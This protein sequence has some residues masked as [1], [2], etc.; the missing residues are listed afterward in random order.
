M[1]IGNGDL[2]SRKTKGRSNPRN[3]IF[4][5]QLFFINM[6]KTLRVGRGCR[7]RGTFPKRAA[8]IEYPKTRLMGD[9]TPAHQRSLSL[10]PSL[11]L[12]LTSM[13]SR[14][15]RAPSGPWSRLKPMNL[16]PLE[17]IGLPSKGDNR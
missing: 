1:R 2:R 10:H 4:I 13:S 15:G 14:G 9:A 5:N 6:C 11:T 12:L 16:D 8:K 7:R 3:E 17:V